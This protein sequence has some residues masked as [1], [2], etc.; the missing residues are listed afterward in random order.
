MIPLTWRAIL[1]SK[2]KTCWRYEGE[3]VNALPFTINCSRRGRDAKLLISPTY[4][5]QNSSNIG[6]YKETHHTDRV[7]LNVKTNNGV[8]FFQS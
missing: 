6:L 1:G 2:L 8:A 7:I 5:I 3:A 4:K